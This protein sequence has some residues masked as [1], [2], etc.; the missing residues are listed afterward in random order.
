MTA[1]AFPMGWWT[2]VSQSRGAVQL[3]AAAGVLEEDERGLG[4]RQC[5]TSPQSRG[6]RVGHRLRRPSVA[7]P[8]PKPTTPP[9]TD[10]TFSRT[11]P[12]TRRSPRRSGRGRQPDIPSTPPDHAPQQEERR[13]GWGSGLGSSA[14]WLVSGIWVKDLT[15]SNG[16]AA[17]CVF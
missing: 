8:P 2:S 9:T 14:M 5:A 12:Q 13:S 10:R 16:L 3:A 6:G 7:F 15:G 1:S 4:H 17:L 11:G